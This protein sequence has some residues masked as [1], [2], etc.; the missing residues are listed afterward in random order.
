MTIQDLL[1]EVDR[2]STFY[3]GSGGGV[4]L[5]GGEPLA[6]YDFLC[7]LLDALKSRGLNTA[8][9]TSGCVPFEELE[10]A[11]KNLNLFLYDIKIMDPE[12]HRNHTG[13]SNDIIL[14]NLRRLDELSKP[15]VIRLP[16]VPGVNDDDRN[17][18]ETVAYLRTLK[19]VIRVSV[20]PY[21]KGGVE[22]RKW[23]SGDQPRPPFRTPSGDAVRGI[24]EALSETRFPVKTGG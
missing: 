24:C 3:E 20:L 19:N 6:Q 23:L 22:K 7:T 13:V 18:A 8:L 2:D 12:K 11:G 5:S 16:V 21:H 4:T 9:D 17:I 10:S 15:I 14:D 1:D